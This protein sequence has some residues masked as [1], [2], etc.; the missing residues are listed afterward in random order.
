[1]PRSPGH[2]QLLQHRSSFHP[3]PKLAPG[4]SP[5]LPGLTLHR[6][7]LQG[8]RALGSGAPQGPLSRPRG[9]ARPP[10]SPGTARRGPR[11]PW[12]GRRRPQGP[13]RLQRA[14]VPGAPDQATFRVLPVE[15]ALPG[16]RQRRRRRG[17]AGAAGTRPRHGRTSLRAVPRCSDPGSASSPLRAQC[18]A[19]RDFPILIP[20][21]RFGNP[22]SGIS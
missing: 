1:M 12:G 5:R 11:G 8:P 4:R 19:I 13:P 7:L 16:R 18:S 20:G 22:G 14:P 9:G 15:A 3:F 17:S 6:F 2:S 10:S 21:P